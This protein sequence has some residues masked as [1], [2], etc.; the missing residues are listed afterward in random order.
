MTKNELIN[1][2]KNFNNTKII[3]TN[4]ILEGL[5]EL[6]A[7]D[8]QLFMMLVNYKNSTEFKKKL[9]NGEI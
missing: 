3:P 1:F 4:V 5:K 8:H 7:R 2:V 6:P 9:D